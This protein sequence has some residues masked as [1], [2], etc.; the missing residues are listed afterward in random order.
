ML[1]L[2]NISQ[3]QILFIPRDGSKDT[4]N[5]TLEVLSTIDKTLRTFNVIDNASSDLYFNVSLSLPEDMP[6]GE[7]EYTLLNGPMVLSKGLLIL[8]ED[9]TNTEYQ[10]TIT[11]EQYI[12]D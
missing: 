12:A 8:T 6:I 1:Y 7:H 2:K 9:V 3:P 10:K 11:Y 4:G 5:L